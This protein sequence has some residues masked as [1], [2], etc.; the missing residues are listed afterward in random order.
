MPIISLKFA[1]FLLICLAI[2]YLLPGRWQNAFLLLAS[3]AYY[4]TWAW[5]YA[6]ILLALAVFNFFYGHYLQDRVRPPLPMAATRAAAGETEPRAAAQRPPSLVA[7]SGAAAGRQTA[8]RTFWLGVGLNVVLFAWLAFDG[9]GLAQ[10][11][12]AKAQWG[13]VSVEAFL[14]LPLGFSYYALNCISYLADIYLKIS[15]PATSFIDF[16][17]YLAYFPKLIS[18][19]LER[20]RRFLPQLTGS[21]KVDN[22]AV[23]HSLALIGLGLFRAVVLAGMLTVLQPASVLEKPEAHAAPELLLGMGVFMVY[24]YNQFAGYTDIVR[25]V[26]GLFGIELSRNF[27]QPFFS[28]D[29]SDFWRRWHISLSQWL[30]DY[31]Y[32]PLSR[33]LLRRN[34]SRTNIPNLILP[35]LVTMLVSGLW[36]GANGHV[37]LWGLLNGCYIM[38]ENLLNLFRPARP[39]VKPPAWR[40]VLSSVGVLGLAMLAAVPFR[41]D[42]RD[43]FVFFYQC[44][45]A[46]KP[47]ALS[48]L[49][50]AIVGLSLLLDGAQARANDE[51]FIL[52]LPWWAQ[53]IAL[54]LLVLAVVV[55]E[56]LQSA[57]AMFV[58]P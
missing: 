7:V 31:I 17:L 30:R 28:Q 25:G 13:S 11:A 51:I 35:P 10:A 41:L 20:W 43:S 40:R 48:L 39:G 37:I 26:S 56:Q 2:Y 50:L 9:F 3:L 58:Y 27:V 24:L 42:L 16:A 21:R 18:G 29:F 52:R 15:T 49:P 14:V 47:Q 23:A 33:L 34:P 4:S 5:E 36:H 1:A 44:L 12:G 6:A 38:L 8:R 55:V 53:S 46:W 45:F 32:M 54:A 22:A 57:P 19:P